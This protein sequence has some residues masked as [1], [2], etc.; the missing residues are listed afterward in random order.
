MIKASYKITKITPPRG[1]ELGGYGFYRDRKN[2]G[3]HDDLFLR[4]LYL[5]QEDE[6]LIL[7]A[8]LLDISKDVYDEVIEKVNSIL[9]IPKTN[10]V[11][12]VT[13]THYAPPLTYLRGCGEVSEDYKKFIINKFIE[14]L[15]DIKKKLHDVSIFYGEG[16]VENV[17]FNRVLKNGPI[18]PMVRV[19][20]VTNSD[21]SLLIFNYSCHPVCIDVRTDDGYYVSCDWPGEVYRIL[22]EK[23]QSETMFLQGTCGNID[24]IVAWKMRGYDAAKEVGE[25]V[26]NAV[27]KILKG[28]IMK[29]DHEL[30]VKSINVRLPYEKISYKELVKIISIFLKRLEMQ[31]S[32]VRI[33]M[34]RLVNN[35]RFY[36]ESL[37]Y[38]YENLEK[39]P[40]YIDVVF[41][42]VK[43]GELVLLFMPGEIFV[44][45]GLKIRQKSPFKKLII[46]G[47]IPER[48]DFDSYGYASYMAPLLLGTLPY[49]RNISEVYVEKALELLKSLT[50]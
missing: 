6:V 14:I 25:R 20:K 33:D 17:S 22:K 28:K 41:T 34:S 39:L 46:I 49:S 31:S 2:K 42:A 13:H 16:K 11:I 5:K 30:K 35:I 44:E 37:E 10:V 21:F 29:I 24:P 19:M 15:K 38:F 40:H 18:D 32:D 9:S 7:N 1:I 12:T 36:R 45:I 3:A 23:Y 27:I 43:I 8:D 4:A 48:Y 47:Y 50:N 26:A